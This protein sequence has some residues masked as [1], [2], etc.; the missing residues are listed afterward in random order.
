MSGAREASYCLPILRQRL[1]APLNTLMSN[2]F[3]FGG[4]SAAL[5]FS[6]FAG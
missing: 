5:V 3:S 1:D 4:T 6:R 2:S